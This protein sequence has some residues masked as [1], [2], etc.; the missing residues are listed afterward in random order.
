MQTEV[1]TGHLNKSTVYNSERKQLCCPT[2][3]SR[4]RGA[5]KN[6]SCGRDTEEITASPSSPLQCIAKH[7][8]QISPRSYQ[9]RVLLNLILFAKK[10]KTTLA[11]ISL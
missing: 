9:N 1:N 6:W 10:K 5:A 11:V 3:R 7:T 8:Q 4:R 2:R